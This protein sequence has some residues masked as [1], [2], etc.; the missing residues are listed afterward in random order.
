MP[1]MIFRTE[2]VTHIVRRASFMTAGLAL[3]F[4]A[5][6]STQADAQRATYASNSG[7][8]QI[9]YHIKKKRRY[10]RRRRKPKTPVGPPAW[11]TKEESKDPVYIVISLPKQKMTVYKGDKVLTTSKVSS[12]KAGYSTPS[13]IFSILE[14]KPRHYSNIYRGAPMPFMQRLT[15]SGIALHSSNSVPNHPA[16]H[17]CV[18]LPPSFAK[19]LFQVTQKGG[20]VVVANEE[21]IVPTDVVHETLFQPT[22]VAPKDYD[23]IESQMAIKRGGIKIKDEER[24]TKPVRVL[25]TRRTGRELFKEMQ[26]M[27]NELSFG[28]GDVDGYMGRDTA[29]AI[30]RFQATYGL[31]KNGFMSSELMDKLY[32]VTGK[33]KPK[34]GHLYVRQN[35]NPV[36]DVPVFINDEEKP[37]GSHMFTAMHFEP[38]DD[39]TRWLS[40]TLT[41]GSGKNRSFGRYA[42]RKKNKKKDD[43]V[44]TEK[45]PLP[46]SAEDAL[47]RVE[48]PDDVRQRINEMLTPGSSFAITND[49]IS[50]ETTPKGTDFIVLMQ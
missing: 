50:K 29:S 5:S 31:P 20:H 2:A 30:R 4:T 11:L 16:S 37:L 15:W 33:G 23:V 26:S 18:R 24:S 45:M 41:K 46:S 35:F 1:Q 48:I 39:Q 22:P 34:N 44:L 43:I 14:R 7:E 47:T 40:V 13:G 42:K 6:V 8:Y 21:N 32:E 36:F 3:L 38:G 19:Q 49:G 17:G 28:A 25:V 9:A 10:V 27:L 12:G